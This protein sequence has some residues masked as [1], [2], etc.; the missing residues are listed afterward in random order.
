[1]KPTFFDS[2]VVDAAR[3]DE[4]QYKYD[5]VVPVKTFGGVRKLGDSLFQFQHEDLGTATIDLSN[6]MTQQFHS[7]RDAGYFRPGQRQGCC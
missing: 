7:Y 6:W 1:M 4:A 2:E 3:V 5:A